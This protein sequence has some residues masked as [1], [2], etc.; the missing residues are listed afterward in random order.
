VKA[1]LGN[2]LIPRRLDNYLARGGYDSQQ[3]DEP[4]DSD[5]EHNLHEP[6]AGDFGAHGPFDDRARDRS[7]QLQA[8]IHRRPLAVLVGLAAAILSVLLGWQATST[9]D[10]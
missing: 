3:T 4:V 7:Y 6:V 2:R 1:I 9:D 8:S 10:G 5:R